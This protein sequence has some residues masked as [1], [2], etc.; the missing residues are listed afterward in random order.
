M[1]QMYGLMG[2]IY[3]FM[4]PDVW[5]YGFDFKGDIA[6]YPKKVRECFESLTKNNNVL[7]NGFIDFSTQT[8][9]HTKDFKFTSESQSINGI[10]PLIA[11]QQV[12][13]I[14]NSLFW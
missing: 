3:R 6:Q 1:D 2:P 14:F 13:F 4:E 12:N 9:I 7:I 8:Y 5:I 11:Y 10:S